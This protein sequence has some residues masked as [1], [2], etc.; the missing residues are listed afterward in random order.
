MRIEFSE[1][2]T[3]LRVVIS[4][5]VKNIYGKQIYVHL[6]EAEGFTD[7]T[8]ELTARY[9]NDQHREA[10]SAIREQA[11]NRGWKDAKAKKTAKLT[12]FTG[13]DDVGDPLGW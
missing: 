13:S 7:L 2:D 10:M 5:T 9:L 1:K 4:T 12:E 6:H 8:A 3:K 11:Y